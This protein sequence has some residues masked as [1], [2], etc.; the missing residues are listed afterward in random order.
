MVRRL[1]ADVLKDLPTKRRQVI[2]IE[3]DDKG[4]ELI[5]KEKVA[6]EN[7]EANEGDPIALSAMSAARKAVA[8]YKVPFIIAHCDDLLET[9]DK[10]VIFAHHHDVI[11]AL[12]AHYTASSVVVDG[13]TKITDRQDLADRFQS[14]PSIKVFIGGIQAAGV[15]I[16]LTAASTMV[17]SELDWV[18]GNMNQAEDRIHRIGQLLQALYHHVILDESLDATMINKVI[19]KQAIADAALDTVKDQKPVEKPPVGL[20]E[21]PKAGQK[22]AIIVVSKSGTVGLNEEQI[23]AIHTG[24]KLLRSRCDGAHAEDGRGFSGTDVRFGWSLAT[25]SKLSAKQAAYGQKLI[26]KYQGQLPT[27]LVIAA[28]VEP[29]N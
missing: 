10:L 29:R 28:G 25:A 9:V 17:F 16:T 4:R 14:D 21:V 19:S 23:E 7:F 26:R 24:I 5:E 13:R 3:P 1:K 20:Q 18:P 11:D 12:R 2:L 22:A 8:I 6:Y 15:G 27:E